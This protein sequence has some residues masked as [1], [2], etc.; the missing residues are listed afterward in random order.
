MATTL[1]RLH[2]GGYLY[3]NHRHFERFDQFV[4]GRLEAMRLRVPG[5]SDV[6]AK[7]TEDGR[8]VLRFQDGS[9]KWTRDPFIA[10]YVSDGT[11]KMFVVPEM[12][13]YEV[14]VPPRTS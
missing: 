1:R 8:L 5:V 9:F 14:S 2:T 11:I 4:R 12:L 3:E 6:E 7:P 13:L 10:R